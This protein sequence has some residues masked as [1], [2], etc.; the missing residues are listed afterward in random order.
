MA[1]IVAA[2][3]VDIALPWFHPRQTW[4]AMALSPVELPAVS[5]EVH[6]SGVVLRAPELARLVKADGGPDRTS[7]GIARRLMHS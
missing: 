1:M 5:D 2:G 6:L 7:N 3:L 4:F